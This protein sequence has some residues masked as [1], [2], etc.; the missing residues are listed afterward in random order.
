MRRGVH[1]RRVISFL[2]RKVSGYRIKPFRH[3]GRNQTRRQFLLHQSE[4]T[5]NSRQTLAPHSRLTPQLPSS[6]FRRDGAQSLPH[7]AGL[8]RAGM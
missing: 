2:T 7:R 6:G 5:L 3:D 1:N 4:L 8:T